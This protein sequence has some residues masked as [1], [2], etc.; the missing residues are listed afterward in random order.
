LCFSGDSVLASVS[1]PFPQ[2]HDVRYKSAGPTMKWVVLAVL[3]SLVL[4]SARPAA[5][6]PFNWTGC[7][8]GINTGWA[9]HR[10]TVNRV[11]P[12]DPNP[13]FPATFAL[14]ADNGTF[15]GQAGCDVQFDRL[16]FGMEVDL[17]GTALSNQQAIDLQAVLGFGEFAQTRS[18]VTHNLDW[19]GTVRGRVGI[20]PMPNLLL[21]FTGG[22]AFG[23]AG[24][25][26]SV[27]A[28][29][30][31]FA[32]NF[33]GSAQGTLYG[34]T[35]GGGVALALHNT[36]SLDVGY[37]YADLGART[38]RLLDVLGSSEVIDFR[39]TH[40]YHMARVALNFHFGPPPAAVALPF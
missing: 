17:Q 13:I 27:I 18:T 1:L 16:V 34:W 11:I 26:A 21:Y 28:T 30:G 39:F 36:V 2:R 15:G 22:L 9:S 23:D 35:A 33:R 7:H 12:A 4:V 19:L 32:I 25:S 10:Q 31:V 3:C 37:R 14:K 40:R 5:A 38:V 29:G 8:A 6:Q 20:T 24:D